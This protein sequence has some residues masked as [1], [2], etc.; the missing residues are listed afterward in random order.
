MILTN[1]LDRFPNPNPYGTDAWI[2]DPPLLKIFVTAP[3]GSWSRDEAYYIAEIDEN[4]IICQP[5]N[6]IINNMSLFAGSCLNRLRF[7]SLNR[8]PCEPKRMDFFASKLIF[9]ACSN[10]LLEKMGHLIMEARRK[11]EENKF[12]LWLRG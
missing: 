12:R 7:H 1:F 2:I 6:F 4:G 11:E 9:R 8:G 3:S 5:P 10:F